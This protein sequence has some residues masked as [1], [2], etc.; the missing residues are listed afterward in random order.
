MQVCTREGKPVIN[1]DEGQ[2]YDY[3][4]VYIDRNGTRY[5][6]GGFIEDFSEESIRKF[7]NKRFHIA[8]GW[9]LKKE[10]IVSIVFEPRI[11]IFENGETVDIQHLPD[12]KWL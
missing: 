2:K 1:P 9:H 7:Y 5:T 10:D 6:S 11:W 3:T 8:T 12:L 4:I